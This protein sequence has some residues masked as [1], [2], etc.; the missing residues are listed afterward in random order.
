MVVKAQE[1]V[2]SEKG[3][4]SPRI[5]VDRDIYQQELENIFARCWLFLCHE[6]QIA[7]PGDFFTTY[8][9]EDPVLVVRDRA[10]KIGAFLNICRHRGNRLCRADSGNAASF[11]C[12]YHG[13]A[14][15]NDGKLEAVPNLKDAYYGEL[16]QENWGLIP[17]AQLDNYKGMVFATFDPAA[18]PLLEYLGEATWFLDSFFDRREGGIEVVGG[19]H[20]WIMPSNWK[21][22]ADNFSGD[23]YHAAWSHLSGVLTGF[24]GSFRTKPKPGG[25]V[26]STNNGHSVAALGPEVV[27]EPP[28]PEVLAYEEQIRPEFEKRLGER[29][30][31]VNPIVG[32]IFPNFSL[33]R[34][35]SPTFR[36]WHPRGPDKIEVWSWGFVDKAAAPEVKA[37][38][39]RAVARGF[40]PSGVFEQDDMDNWQECTNTSRGVVSRRIPLNIQMG[41]GHEG[42]DENFM[43]RTSD[44]RYSEMGH[45]AYY[46]R[47]AQLMS[48]ESWADL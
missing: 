23:G 47:W 16:D 18:P 32:T 28:S 36:V 34:S 40:S 9:G 27:A 26:I 21:V 41:I 5:F 6:S 2:D 15:S 1:L 20:R 24:A 11:I 17:V 33:L 10:G 37:A 45:R 31:L 19:V 22:P 43:A 46:H 39:R 4:I 3:L 48:A 30:R 35:T 42:F 13:W 25:G 38:S 14:Y 7:S 12:A 8:M 29:I 44:Y